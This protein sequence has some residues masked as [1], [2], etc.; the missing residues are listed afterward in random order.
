MITRKSTLSWS[1]KHVGHIPAIARALKQ[2]M[3][4]EILNT[5]DANRGAVFFVLALAQVFK[6]LIGQLRALRSIQVEPVPSLWYG[7]TIK[8]T[9]DFLEEKFNP[10]LDGCPVVLEVIS[11]RSGERLNYPLSSYFMILTAG[12][13]SNR[14]SKTA[15]DI[16]YDEP[17]LYEP[18]WIGEIQRRR[19]D[20]PRDF[21]E[22]FMTTGPDAGSHA[23]H[24]WENTDQRIWHARCPVCHAF[25]EPRF[26]HKN[27]SGDIIGGVRFETILRADNL[28]DEAAIQKST[29]YECPKCQARF[30]DSPGS[31]AALNGTADQPHGL[32]VPQN[33]SPSP[34]HFGWQVNGCAIRD[35]GPLAT[36]FVYAQLARERG[37]LT[38]MKEIV[39]LD[40]AGLWDENLYLSQRSNRT[41]GDY[42]MGQDWDGEL[43]DEYK[44]PW[45]FATIDVQNDCYYLVIRMWGRFSESRLRF[46][47]RVLSVS[48]LEILCAEHGVEK[49]RV[50]MDSRWEAQRVRRIAAIKGWM[51]LMGDKQNS[52]GYRHPDGIF[53]IY[54]EMKVY[55][56]LIGTPDQGS[57]SNVIEILFSKQAAL[58]RLHLLRTEKLQLKR[59]EGADKDP[60]PRPLWTA[61]ANTPDAYWPQVEAHRRR[62]K[63]NPDGSEYWVW[64]GL[65]ED[66]FGDCEAMQV[67]AASM[68]GLTGAESMDQA[69]AE[70][71]ATPVNP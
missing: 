29:V 45:R 24:I 30:P 8:N 64:E 37:D 35:W 58:N 70:S 55:D 67:I 4:P 15:C 10:L 39:Q 31:R 63:T 46:A 44:R 50:F 17:W 56:P 6:S 53:R 19:G 68:C 69:P 5:I 49:F 47:A 62:M 51:T 57:G 21:R 13:D 71:P 1:R 7:P 40:F 41:I 36:K 42:T 61:A 14:Q 48:D 33:S 26:A 22:I 23:A 9:S 18:G 65:K 27:A 52:R 43:R 66:H 3:I 20:Y 32:Y 2:P 38:P 59:P 54:D 16:Y 25:F 11:K 60:D 34:N 28:P 12:A